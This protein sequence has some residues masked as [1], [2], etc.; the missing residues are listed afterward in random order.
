MKKRISATRVV[1]EFSEILNTIKFKGVHYII[2]RSG[3]P[4]ASMKSIEEKIDPMT[5]GELKNLL[6]KLPRL[7]NE[8]DAFA[9][10]LEE[11]SRNQ[12]LMSTGDLWE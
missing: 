9:S 2:E 7:E 12:P 6:K 4:I 1:R 10:D 3:K 8:L 5:L 11:I